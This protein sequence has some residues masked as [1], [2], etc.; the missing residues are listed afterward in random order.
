M[1]ITITDNLIEFL[2][3]NKAILFIFRCLV[4]VL[5]FIGAVVKTETVWSTADLFM[6]LMAIVNLVSIIGLSNIA[7]AVMKDYIQ[8][9]VPV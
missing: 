2:S 5:V 9:N 3:K 6:G 4:V 7:F 1:V 8:Q